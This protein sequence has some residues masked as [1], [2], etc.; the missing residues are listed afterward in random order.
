HAL[1]TTAWI[2][3]ST[4][5]QLFLGGKVLAQPWGGHRTRRQARHADELD[6]LLGRGAGQDLLE[7][8]VGIPFLGDGE[9]RTDLHGIGAMAEPMADL[10]MT[11]YAACHDQRWRLAAQAQFVEKRP[12]LL[13]HGIERKTWIVQILDARRPKMSSGMARM[14]DDHGIGTALLFQ[15]ALHDHANASGVGQNGY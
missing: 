2:G 9:R 1:G 7:S 3:F 5:L 11:V 10:V 8:L 12:A 13:Q 14:L 6:Q 4:A 15:P